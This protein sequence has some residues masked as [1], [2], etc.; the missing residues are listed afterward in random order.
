MKFHFNQN[1]LF[2]SI[3]F[4]QIAFNEVIINEI[5]YHSS[6]NFNSHD[7]IEFYN[8]SSTEIDLVGWQFKDE[9]DDHIFTF[10]QN[11]LIPANGFMVLCKNDS[12]FTANYPNITNF[13]GEMD[14]GL[15]GGGEPIRLFNS[16]GNLVDSVNY[17]D[18]PPWVLEPD[19]N[20]PTLE[21]IH[22]SLDNSIPENWTASI[23]NGTPGE[24]NTS[25]L[26]VN[27]KFGLIKKIEIKSCYP[28]PFNN[29]TTINFILN[30]SEYLNIE[31]V[32][33]NGKVVKKLKSGIYSFGEHSIQIVLN[34]T[35][36]GTY[37]IKING[38]NIFDGNK[39][40]LIK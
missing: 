32:D 40:T 36:S 11:T 28:N 13:I 37:F 5:N 10:P 8:P 39:I 16:E 27:E 9:V 17:D 31:L 22:Y 38:D 20:G 34:E 30:K 26:A 3:I 1:Y 24:I 2:Y 4:F 35:P 14:F 6:D 25:T 19:D 12:A 33:I 18:E 15:S 29:S 7:W 23:G 21:L